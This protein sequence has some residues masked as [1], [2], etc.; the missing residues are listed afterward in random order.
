MLA[1]LGLPIARDLHG[2]PLLEYFEEGFLVPSS[3]RFVET[4]GD[5]SGR[6]AGT[7]RSQ[8]DEEILEE[9]RSLGYIE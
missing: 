1:H 6:A 2:E 3:L 4:Y 5:E 8:H 7:R 9:L